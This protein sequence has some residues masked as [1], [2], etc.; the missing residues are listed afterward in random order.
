MR[1]RRSFLIT[2]LLALGL[3][4]TLWT[5]LKAA[6][7]VLARPEFAS[8]P[9]EKDSITSSG[10]SFKPVTPE[11]TPSTPQVITST[12]TEGISVGSGWGGLLCECYE[13]D[14]ECQY[15]YD[16]VYL[17]WEGEV[18][19][20]TLV[21]NQFHTY[22]LYPYPPSW[23]H[24]GKT[25]YNHPR[26]GLLRC[27][28]DDYTNRGY[29][30][31]IFVN[32][33][34]VGQPKPDQGGMGHHW[35]DVGGAPTLFKWTLDPA[36]ISHT[37]SISL[38]NFVTATLKESKAQGI[39]W[40]LKNVRIRIEGNIKGLSYNLFP[41]ESY[42]KHFLKEKNHLLEPV[43]YPSN[44]APLLVGFPGWGEKAWDAMMRYAPYAFERGWFL[45]TP[46]L[47]G[48]NRNFFYGYWSGNTLASRYAQSDVANLIGQAKS[49]FAGRLNPN[50]V[51]GIGFSTGGMTALTFAA[52]EP[53]LYTAVADEK[54]VTDL[55]AWYYERPWLQGWIRGEVGDAPT[56]VS[57]NYQ[58]RSGL[59]MASNL[60]HVPLYITHGFTDTK[61]AYH[62]SDDV[63]KAL[64]SYDA[65]HVEFYPF[66][67]EHA[68]PPPGGIS[69][70][71]DFL[72]QWEFGV[73][74]TTVPASLTIHTDESK[75]YYWLRINQ[76]PNSNWTS[77]SATYDQGSSVITVSITLSGTEH[78]IIGFNLSQMGLITDSDYVPEGM[79][80]IND[81]PIVYSTISPVLEGGDYWLSIALPRGSYR[82]ILYPAT[83]PAPPFVTQ[84]IRGGEDTYIDP[85]NPEQNYGSASTIQVG[86]GGN[87]AA[88]LRF[89]LSSIPFGAPIRAAVLKLY[90]L[91][92][93]GSRIPLLVNV[94]RLSR[95]WTVSE[96]TWLSATLD[97]AWAAPGAEGSEDRETVVTDSRFIHRLDTWGTWYLFDVT[98]L[99][100][101]WM[102]SPADNYGLILKGVGYSSS[103]YKVHYNIASSE[104]SD[105]SLRP[106]LVVVYEETPTPTPTNTLTPTPTD[107]LTPTP[108]NTPT[109]TPTDTPTPTPTNTPTPTPTPT[110]TDTPT[111]TPTNTSTPT[112]TPTPTPYLIYL[113]VLFKVF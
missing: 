59:Y 17:W 1:K 33:H 38:T 47:R 14:T 18:T 78:A 80:A 82:F 99:V 74:V 27:S 75:T 6:S 73:N 7:P 29:C 32:G 62:H 39:K 34:F 110:S 106:K 61:V 44:P 19:A 92:R 72:G 86:P 67:G 9:H 3:V 52:K 22:G 68:D 108:T 48:E 76:V 8:S 50:R 111:P 2:P 10:T 105:E 55:P 87:K 63:Y 31:L 56:N 43:G 102:Q 23:G 90:V 41:D 91:S 103:T 104:Y 5:L 54:G 16:M 57:F 26:Y 69:A 81:Q 13:G 71:L 42:Y 95:S 70:M 30:P 40:G 12:W 107:T 25:W 64:L 84:V 49:R 100:R 77:V 51:Y 20:A 101:A 53:D 113:P 89:D 109:P 88:L 83:N 65:Q 60:Q 66:E 79:D 93:T 37:N 112:S 46:Y 96:T 21:A 11:D 94:H 15:G 85:A 35:C 24:Y 28:F 4:L 45:L 98:N 58:R 97:E 36:I